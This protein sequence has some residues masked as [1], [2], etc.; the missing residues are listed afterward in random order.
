MLINLLSTFFF[1]NKFYQAISLNKNYISYQKALVLVIVATLLDDVAYYVFD[2]NY[3]LSNFSSIFYFSEV[4][5][6]VFV[7]SLFA[8]IFGAGARASQF[9]LVLRAYSYTLSPVIIG[10]VILI[11]IST[12]TN[13]NVNYYDAVK[14]AAFLVITG[15]MW[16]CQFICI[17]TIFI[18]LGFLKRMFLFLVTVGIY[19][20]VDKFKKFFYLFLSGSQ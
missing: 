7:I 11:I 20:G 9:G 6:S 13:C 16:L 4:I 12:T 8:R 3:A 18:K 17:Q 10:S 2:N 15:W 19:I 5:L 1:S 14:L